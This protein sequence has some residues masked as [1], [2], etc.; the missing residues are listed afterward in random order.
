[1]PLAAIRTPFPGDHW[2]YPDRTFWRIRARFGKRVE[3]LEGGNRA[4][5]AGFRGGDRE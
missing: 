4:A 2:W 5:A 1:M 3:T